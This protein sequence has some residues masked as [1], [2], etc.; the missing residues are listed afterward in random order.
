M[1]TKKE[2]QEDRY[3]M[4]DERY[5]E[6]MAWFDKIEKTGEEKNTSFFG[7]MRKALYPEYRRHGNGKS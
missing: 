6:A 5:K 4:T 2:N 1:I 3:R 7:L